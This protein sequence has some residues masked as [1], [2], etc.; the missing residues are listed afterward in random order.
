MVVSTIVSFSALLAF[1]E[2][3]PPVTR[4][5]PSQKPVTGSFDFFFDLRKDWANNRDSG[6][7]ERHRVHY[8]VTVMGAW[9]SIL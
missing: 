3:N 8:N 1:C 9:V 2:G 6:D 5:F 4:G 7:L